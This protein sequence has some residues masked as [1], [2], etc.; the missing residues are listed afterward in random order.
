MQRLGCS[1]FLKN[2]GTLRPALIRRM[3]R[4]NLSDDDAKELT[5]YIMTVYQTPAFDR[6]SM[7]FE[8]LSARLRWSKGNSSSIPSMPARSCH[9]VDTKVDKGY[10]GPNAHAS[11]LAADGAVDLSLAEG[12][13]GPAA[14]HHRTEPQYERRRCPRADRIPDDAEGLQQAGGEEM[15]SDES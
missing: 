4:F 6:D 8:R 5:D 3:P 11:W 1:A 2:P 9:I 15:T 10:I 12:S 14:R 7:P 13:A